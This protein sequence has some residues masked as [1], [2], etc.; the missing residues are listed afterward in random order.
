[1]MEEQMREKIVEEIK[2]IENK[3]DVKVLLAVE[4]GSRAWG[5]ASP[6]SDYDVR[7]IYVRRPDEYLRLDKVRDVIEYPINDLLD[8]NGWDYGK[9]LQLLHGSNP[10]LY[11]W[12]DSRI[13]YAEHPDF[14]SDMKPL[15]DQYFSKKKSLGHYLHMARNNAKDFIYGDEVKIKKY[16]YV[17]RALLAAKWVVEKGGP[18]PILFSELLDSELSFDYRD[19]VDSLLFQK[20]NVPELKMVKRNDILNGYIDNLF[21]EL[22]VVLDSLQ[23][24][25]E[26]WFSLNKAFQIGI[27]KYWE[28]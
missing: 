21:A 26:D 13:V 23:D 10:T 17:L 25:T 4:S 24:I 12:L 28:V 14:K 11:E 7:F 2:N 9:M 3:E 19:I 20:Q 27:K 8:I 15:L 22:Q 6:D 1:M 18:A 16:F 5:F